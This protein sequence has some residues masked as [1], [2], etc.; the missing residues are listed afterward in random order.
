MSGF[1]EG[2]RRKLVIKNAVLCLACGVE[3][4]CTNKRDAEGAPVWV[5]HICEEDGF[6][7]IGGA[8]DQLN[9]SGSHYCYDDASVVMWVL[10]LPRKFNSAGQ[11]FWA[12]TKKVA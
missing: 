2:Y 4:D 10:E 8:T 9:R 3:V 1:P 6:F 11:A 12:P 5:P 7:S